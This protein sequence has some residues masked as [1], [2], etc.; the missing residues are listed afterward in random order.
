MRYSIIDRS[1]STT[2]MARWFAHTE[3]P[4]DVEYILI[5]PVSKR[6]PCQGEFPEWGAVRVLSTEAQAGANELTAALKLATGDVLIVPTTSLDPPAGWDTRL[7]GVVDGFAKNAYPFTRAADTYKAW[8][9]KPWYKRL[10][11]AIWN[12]DLGLNLGQPAITAPADKVAL[13]T[14]A[15]FEVNGPVHILTRNRFARIG[16]DEPGF[17]DRAVRDGVVVDAR[18]IQWADG[19]SSC[20]HPVTRAKQVWDGPLISVLHPT[21]RIAPSEAFPR[22]WRDSHD[23]YLAKCDHPENV[24]YIL[25]VHESRW[26]EFID[27][28]LFQSCCPDMF[29][30]D[31]LEISREA[32]RQL[33]VGGLVAFLS[34]GRFRAVINRQRDCAVDQLNCAGAAST[35]RLITATM[36]D[37][38]PPE[39]WDTLLLGATPDLDDS[40]LVLCSS[41][42][43][44]QRDRELMIASSMTRQRYGQLGHILDPRFESMYSDNWLAYVTNRDARKGL[45]RIIERFDIHFDHRHPCFG[46]GQMDDIYESHG[47]TEAHERGRLVLEKLMEAEGFSVVTASKGQGRKI[48]ICMPGSGFAARYVVNLIDLIWSLQRS[49][50]EVLAPFN[51]YSSDPSNTREILRRNVMAGV[52]PDLVLWMDHDNILGYGEFAKLVLDLESFPDLGAIFAW[53]WLSVDSWELPP[54]VS[55]GRVDAKGLGVPFSV[56]EMYDAAK[57]S[58]LIQV[59]YSGFPAVLMRYSVLESAGAN[60]FVPLIG[61]QYDMGKSGEDFAFCRRAIEAG[62]KMAVDPQVK[63]PHLKLGDRDPDLSK[64]LQMAP[65]V[66]E[67]VASQPVESHAA[68]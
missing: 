3:N 59:G 44:E 51:C 52:K 62:I 43:T 11:D 46:K 26:Q 31:M 53:C 19:D 34:W 23:A 56:Q 25:V 37:Y 42:A 18:H 5:L 10:W 55:C 45:V 17:L 68:D 66:T 4:Q 30:Q 47:G 15:V 7:S 22:G 24:E 9:P 63:I 8:L 13:A 67:Q 2:D 61:P 16:Y 60:P 29:S 6:A 33:P 41:G 39:H 27:S 57:A 35:G 40:Y 50:Y 28:G 58:Q 21:A 64:V 48:A 65:N 20:L 32:A 49:G 54:M 1:G 14:E 36:D 12:P 38:F